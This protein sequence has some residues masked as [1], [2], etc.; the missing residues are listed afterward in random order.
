M[1]RC[2]LMLAITGLLTS[3]SQRVA[4][5]DVSVVTSA[6]E[7]ECFAPK[8]P[9]MRVSPHRILFGLEGSTP[10]EISMAE[11]PGKLAEVKD[12]R[13]DREVIYLEVDDGVPFAQVVAIVDMAQGMA[14]SQRRILVEPDGN[15]LEP[16]SWA[17][18]AYRFPAHDGP[19]CG[20]PATL[21]RYGSSPTW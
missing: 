15:V 20:P 13:Q 5:L 17:R 4:V 21:S 18:P 6:P 2:R 14:F 19:P 8:P 11:L 7:L 3:P 1:I 12:D 10:R 16:A 9:L